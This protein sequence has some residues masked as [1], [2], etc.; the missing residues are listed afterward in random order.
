VVPVPGI[1]SIGPGAGSI[2]GG[3]KVAVS[4]HD[5][6]GATAVAFGGVAAAAYT[7]DSDAQITATSPAAARPGPVDIS[8]TTVGGQTPTVPADRFTYAACV[9]PKLKGLRLKAVRRRLK[10]ADCALG[11]VKRAAGAGRSAKVR[12]Q[13]ARPG[14]VLPPRSKVSVRLGS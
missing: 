6:S 9:V 2:K 7:V 5:L 1:G 13:G 10:A 3:T 4:G 11:R 12:K 14:S 8:V